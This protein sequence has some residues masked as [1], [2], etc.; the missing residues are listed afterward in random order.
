MLS[1]IPFGMLEQ[2]R[3][4]VAQ[5]PKEDL[6]IEMRLYQVYVLFPLI[7]VVDD[8]NLLQ[9][10]FQSKGESRHT[11]DNQARE[12]TVHVRVLYLCI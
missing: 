8:V 7:G 6:K 12:Y 10:C 11:Y 5:V 1:S 9:K 3:G 2:H 4:N